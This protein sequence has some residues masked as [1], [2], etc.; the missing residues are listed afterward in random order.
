MHATASDLAEVAAVV[1]A[2][3]ESTEV[4]VGEGAG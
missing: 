2:E 1:E 3:I 4:V